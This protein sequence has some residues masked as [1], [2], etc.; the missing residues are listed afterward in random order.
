MTLTP[1]PSLENI[2]IARPCNASWEDMEGDERERFCHLCQKKVYNLTAMTREQ[3]ISWLEYRE[4]E[5]CVR[6]FRRPDGTVMT[7]DCGVALER[8]HQN[9]QR[10]C[11]IGLASIVSFAF[12]T[13]ILA[14]AGSL[15][16]GVQSNIRSLPVIGTV[17][18]KLR[19]VR[20][21]TMGAVNLKITPGGSK[22]P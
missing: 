17:L 1:R 4:G 16:S 2:H 3:A 12:W 20:V 8:Q 9:A 22:Q 7:N 6:L 19:P 13:F 14:A 15:P 21:C 5:T 11:R 18:E 10:N